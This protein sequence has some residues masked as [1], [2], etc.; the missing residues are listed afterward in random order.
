MAVGAFVHAEVEIMTEGGLASL[1]LEND[2]SRFVAFVTL[3]ALTLY[4]EGILAVMAGAAGFAGFH[5]CH[6][7]LGGASLVREGFCMAVRAF[8]HA[9]MDLVAE[10]SVSCTLYLEG[11]LTWFHPFM[12]VAAVAGNGEG[13]L[14]VMAGAAGLPLF[15]LRHGDASVLTGN[16][17]AVMAAF[18]GEFGFGNV[19]I[20]AEGNLRCALYFKGHRSW[21]AFMALCAELLILYAECFHAGMACAA[22][23]CCFHFRHGESFLRPEVEDGVVA[24]PAVVVVFLQ[25]EIV[26]E[27]DRIGILEAERDIF[28][29]LGKGEYWQQCCQA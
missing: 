16:N 25:V 22:G 23:L 21:F 3:V 13:F 7:C 20:V 27:D 24:D 14:V 8:E 28:C 12:A 11:D 19:S 17:L 4:G 26:A 29:L 6:G 1:C 9:D 5:C 18:A 15:H 2:I 10:N